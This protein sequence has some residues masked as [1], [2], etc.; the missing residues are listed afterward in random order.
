MLF[1]IGLLY[2]KGIKIKDRK[3]RLKA[4]YGMK[5]AVVGFAGT[6]DSLLTGEF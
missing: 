1:I 2:S 5:N 3:V 4:G 6:I